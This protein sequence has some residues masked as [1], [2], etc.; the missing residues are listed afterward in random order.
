MYEKI[1]PKKKIQKSRVKL[2]TYSGKRLNV[3]GKVL[4]FVE[5]KG[6]FYTLEFLIVDQENAHPILG[7]QACD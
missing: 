3:V 6:R 5:Y 4:E 7:I 2:S 1:N